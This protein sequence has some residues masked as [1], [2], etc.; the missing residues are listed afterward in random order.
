MK[1]KPILLYLML[2]FVLVFSPAKPSHAADV[3]DWVG[4]GICSILYT[5]LK[6]A[7][8]VLMGVTGGLSLI[9]TVPAGDVEASAQIVRWG[10]YG[11]WLIRPDHLYGQ[12]PVRLIG[13]GN[14]AHFLSF[15]S[16]LRAPQRECCR[17]PGNRVP[18]GVNAM[19]FSDPDLSNFGGHSIPRDSYSE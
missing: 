19:A 8:A 16:D 5:P 13:T 14:R 10:V 2:T 1:I 17:L 3:S 12:T 11:D 18:E 15:D 4:A 9:A 6:T 7:F